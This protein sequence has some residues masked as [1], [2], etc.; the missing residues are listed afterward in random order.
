LT[1]LSELV[2]AMVLVSDDE[3]DRAIVTVLE[4][5]GEVAECAG[6]AAFAALDKIVPGVPGGETV[7]ILSGGNLPVS[8]LRRLL[9]KERPANDAPA[10]P[11]R[12]EFPLAIFNQREP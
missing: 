2:D 3:L 1:V 11:S 8:D 9:A 10:S 5:T 4:A 12:H 7:L 6:A